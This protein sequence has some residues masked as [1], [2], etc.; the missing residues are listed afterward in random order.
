MKIR[1]PPPSPHPQ[2]STQ[3]PELEKL[4]RYFRWRGGVSQSTH[5]TN[6][7]LHTHSHTH[8]S[9]TMWGRGVGEGGGG[10]GLDEWEGGGGRGLRKFAENLA[11]Q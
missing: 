1:K 8:A 4:G 5:M 10:G 11:N 7:E 3:K 9:A 6:F 2:T